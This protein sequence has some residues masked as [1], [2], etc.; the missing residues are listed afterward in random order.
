MP[1][2]SDVRYLAAKQTAGWA[3]YRCRA[4]AIST[5]LHLRGRHELHYSKLSHAKGGRSYQ[6]APHFNGARPLSI[7]LGS[8]K[9]GKDTGTVGT[10]N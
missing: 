4:A 1:E 2:L 5:C 3:T 10:A 6:C 8:A 7:R 9:T